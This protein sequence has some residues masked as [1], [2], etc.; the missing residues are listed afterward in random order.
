[1]AAEKQAA[2][3]DSGGHDE[4][5]HQRRITPVLESDCAVVGPA[6][7]VADCRHFDVALFQRHTGFSDMYSNAEF[8]ILND[9]WLSN[10]TMTDALISFQTCDY[11]VSQSRPN[12]WCMDTFR[13]EHSSTATTRSH[14]IEELENELGWLQMEDDDYE[15]DE[16]HDALVLYSLL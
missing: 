7:S 3:G 11:P 9:T 6:S 12:V 1:M 8:R 15:L 16:N 10:D 14:G 2:D 13:Y 4:Q 5:A